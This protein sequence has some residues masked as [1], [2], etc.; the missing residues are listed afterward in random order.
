MGGTKSKYA[1]RGKLLPARKELSGQ[2]KLG[3][4]Y[5][6]CLHPRLSHPCLF[7]L[8]GLLVQ[9]TLDVLGSGQNLIP[10]FQLNLD[11]SHL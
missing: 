5:R 4:N 3:E 6:A 11:L 7:C 2:L 1:E 8:D 9:A 10:K